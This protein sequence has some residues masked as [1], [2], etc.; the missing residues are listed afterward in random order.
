MTSND[1]ASDVY[2]MLAANRVDGQDLIIRD[3]K[4]L[5]DGRAVRYAVDQVGLPLLI[6]PIAGAKPTADFAGQALSISTAKDGSEIFVRCLDSRLTTQFGYLADD[7][8]RE[9]ATAGSRVAS[10]L[11][12]VLDNWSELFNEAPAGV[13]SV[14][15]QIGLLAELRLL[16]A[17]LVVNP[18]SLSTWTGPS[19]ARHDFQGVASAVE[20]KATAKHH[21]FQIQIHGFWQLEPP[22]GSTLM[23]YAE[24]VER[25]ESKVAD[26]LSSVIGR[27]HALLTSHHEFDSA[28]ATLGVQAA[29]LEVYE[30]FRFAVLEQRLCEVDKEFPRI[31]PSMFSNS[32]LSQIPGL[33]YAVNIGGVKTS[34]VGNDALLVAAKSLLVPGA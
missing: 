6:V 28:L 19:G 29:R 3:A 1:A 11:A 26:S 30:D 31:A 24:R 16:E 23:V 7:M 32:T 12:N 17:L 27:I 20:V 25:T 33:E 4:V 8:L 21:E 13:L 18:M 34:A 9:L 5:I 15:S 14:P 2:R 22:D 10:V